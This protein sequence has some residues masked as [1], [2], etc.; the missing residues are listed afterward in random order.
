[1]AGGGGPRQGAM[2]REGTRLIEG[3]I[4]AGTDYDVRIGRIGGRPSGLLI[5]GDIEVHRPWMPA[6]ETLTAAVK[7]I[8]VRYRFLDFLSKRYDSRISLEVVEPRIYWRPRLHLR[9]PSFPFLE[10]MRRWALSRKDRLTVNIRGMSLELGAV[11]LERIGVFYDD[12]RF[13]AEV[14]LSHL[15]VYGSDVSTVIKLDG[16]FELGGERSGDRALGMI[17]TEGSVINWQPLA[18]ETN[19]EFIFSREY[20]QLVSSDFLGGI[21]VAG[22]IDFENDFALDITLNTERHPLARFAPFVAGGSRVAVPGQLDLNLK[23]RGTLLEPFIEAHARIRDGL[24][25]QHAFEA[26]DINL[27]GFYPTLRLGNSRILTADGVSMRFADT[28]LEAGSLFS[29]RTY[30]A[31]VQQAAQ[32]NVEWGEWGV[33]RPP[34]REDPAQV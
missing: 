34:P 26:M 1:M 19:F 21:C 10:W 22:G 6:G 25:G 7:E 17:R 12:N 9:R 11:K 33:S 31:L 23:V 32:D 29:A 13:R 2:M 28:V 4:R 27:E 18:G 8:R 3:W 20:F 24:I 14:P 15:G 30:R 5:L 16:H